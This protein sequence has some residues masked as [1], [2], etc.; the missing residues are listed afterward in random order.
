MG[1]K[2][3][4]AHSTDE[5]DADAQEDIAKGKPIKGYTGE[6]VIYAPH[7]TSENDVKRTILHETVGHKGLR[8][9]IGEENFNKMMVQM[10]LMLPEKVRL[11]FGVD[12]VEAAAW[13]N[14]AIDIEI[15]QVAFVLHVVAPLELKVE[16]CS[17]D[18]QQGARY[19]QHHAR[20]IDTQLCFTAIVPYPFV[21]MTA[22]HGGLAPLGR[23]VV[24]DEVVALPA[25]LLV[26]VDIEK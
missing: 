20:T 4:V 16:R 10:Y 26:A 11:L 6:V 23:T 13:R 3:R 22:L 8:Q 9:L 25:C 2:V 21:L 19:A 5:L 1:V 14:I 18:T 7:A 24:D 17:I 12:V 15:H